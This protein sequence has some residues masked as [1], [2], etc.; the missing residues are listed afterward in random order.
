MTSQL[1]A[2]EQKIYNLLVNNAAKTKDI[3]TEL[4]LSSHTIERYVESLLAKKRVGS[5]KELIVQHYKDIIKE[6]TQCPM[7]NI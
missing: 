7:P 5:Q 2:T 6:L 1:T 3:A 4:G